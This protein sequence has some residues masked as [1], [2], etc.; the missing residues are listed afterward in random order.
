MITNDQQE[1]VTALRELLPP[2]STVRTILRHVSQ[3]GMSRDISVVISG[4]GIRDV[5]YLVA[6]A[7][8]AQ[9]RPNGG[10]RRHGCGMDMGFELIYSLS[11]TLYP[12]GYGCV[13]YTLSG[14]DLYQAGD[15]S[16]RC[17]AND[18]VNPPYPK[19]YM[20]HD[21]GGYALRQEWL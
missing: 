8:G 17:P 3:S 1:A 10:I 13:Q 9:V 11:R 5:T 16:R 14:A 12:H 19:K 2:G 6:R 7:L 21:N 4:D 18:H 15:R 20:H